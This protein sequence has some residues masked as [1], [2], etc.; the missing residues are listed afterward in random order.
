MTFSSTMTTTM[1]MTS[2]ATMI[3]MNDGK[4]VAVILTAAGSSS[5]FGTGKKKEW[6]PLKSP[7]VHN[8]YGTVLSCCA[9][10]FLLFF[11]EQNQFK[12][13]QLIITI[14]PSEHELARQAL[15]ASSYVK[16][17][18]QKY[19]IEPIFVE[20]SDTRQKSVFCALDYLH[21]G[22][23]MCD[24]VLIHDAARPFVSK[25]IVQTVIEKAY[26]CGASVP[27]IMPV[28]TQKETDFD[29][30]IIRHL[31][32]TKLAAVQT[33]Q[34]FLFP[35]LYEAHKK[36]SV[37]GISYTDDTAIWANYESD[38]YVVDGAAENIKI[39][40][41]HDMEKKI[42]YRTGLGYDLHKLVEN[43]PLLI[44][45]VLIP[46]EKG[47]EAHSDGDVLL[48]AI[49][50][51]LLGGAGLGDIGE[52]FPPSDMAW[53]NADSKDL[54]KTAWVR[55]QEKGWAIENIDCVIQ[56]EKPKFIPWRQKVIESIAA[57]LEIDSEKVFVKAKTGE[58]LG[59]IGTSNAISVQAICLLSR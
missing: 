24:I 39:T 53:K 46:F 6:L 34:G 35:Q 1:M 15:F 27:A 19:A 52:M 9:E 59:D 43:R 3:N 23:N 2:L 50:D 29:G 32:R 33:P 12:L 18:L 44:G 31:D 30:K 55:V 21:S 56:L 51:C 47:E 38:V 16:S 26:S 58:G 49:T 8:T 40:F 11:A 25:S 7:H 36:A 54:L 48:H 42:E 28:D 10:S 22:A 57:I 5:R 13:S 17:A 4:N 41:R 45:G 20:G 14:P 37:D